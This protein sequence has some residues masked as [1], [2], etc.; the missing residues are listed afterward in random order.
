[1]IA[2]PAE[3]NLG[4]KEVVTTGGH[5]AARAAGATA[6]APAEHPGP[7]LVQTSRSS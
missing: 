2:A 4:E 7:W 3:T 1:M 6:P 5:E